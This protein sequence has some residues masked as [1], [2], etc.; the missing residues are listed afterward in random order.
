MAEWMMVRLSES[1]SRL[2]DSP[3]HI[4][5]LLAFIH[6]RGSPDSNRTASTGMR[7]AAIPH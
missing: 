2:Q 6:T 3:D 1:P 7:A 5:L 4:A